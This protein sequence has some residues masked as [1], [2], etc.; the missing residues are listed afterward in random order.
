MAGNHPKISFIVHSFNRGEYLRET[1]DSILNQG[2]PNLELIV[3]D[4]N[5][6]DKSWELIQEYGARITYKERLQGMRMSPTYALNVGFSHATGEILGWLNAKNILMH[7]S[8]FAVAE[9]FATYAQVEWLTGVGLIINSAGITA[10]IIPIRKDYYES[11]LSLPWNIQQESTF[12]RKSLWDRTGGRFDEVEYPW[13]FDV[14]LWD[15]KFFHTAKLYHLNTIL[16]AYRKLPT[17]QSS[18]RTGEFYDY[19]EKARQEM[20][21]RVKKSDLVYAEAY[22]ALRVLK[23]LLRNIP[24]GVYAK[25]PL[26]NRFCHLSIAFQNL[27]N[28]NLPYLKIYKRNPFRTIFPW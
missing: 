24:D 25:I 15:T 3:I 5:S 8:L 16:G 17:A 11:L 4:D 7:K 26:L 23:P 1:L 14:A 13:A 20:R 22:W 19:V 12:F 6:S 27:N 28:P 21:G 10:N 2:Y 9:V 18:A